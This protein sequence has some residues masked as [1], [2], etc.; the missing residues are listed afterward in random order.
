MA[1][2]FRY[3]AALFIAAISFWPISASADWQ[4]TKWGMSPSQVIKASKGMATLSADGGIAPMPF[5]SGNFTF[6]VRFSFDTD[7]KLSVVYVVLKSGGN[8]A[9]LNAL[10][11][12]YGQP[13]EVDGIT[14]IWRTPR[15]EIL[16][17]AVDADSSDA[18]I[19]YRSRSNTNTQ[20]L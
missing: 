17:S 12:K 10:K 15:D 3:S 6:T 20:G 7:S 8:Y 4:F 1:F 16:F 2:R 18:S 11:E 19:Y 5:A 9:L 14:T 13:D